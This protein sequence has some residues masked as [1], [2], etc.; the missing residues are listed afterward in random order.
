MMT[1]TDT[2][3]SRVTL[4]QARPGLLAD[5]AR[6][7]RWLMAATIGLIAVHA[8]HVFLGERVWELDRIFSLD[9]ESNLPT[10]FSSLMWAGAAI[11]AYSC[12][13]LSRLSQDRRLWTVLA[14]VLMA[15]S[16]DE[17]ATLHELVGKLT[18]TAWPLV[19][20]PIAVPAMIWMGW[21]LRH[22]LARSSGAAKRIA[23]GVAALCAAVACELVMVWL[24]ERPNA[25]ALLVV[26]V[27]VEESL[28][29]FGVALV[30]TGLMWHLRALRAGA[31]RRLV[32]AARA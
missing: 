8:A 2:R 6:L 23:A 27:V 3:V 22:L 4:D 21:R 14:V 7:S 29:L 5:P 25:D 12:G 24:Q 1:T 31:M 26:E 19:L 17:V 9:R 28:E 15:F 11:T 32:A 20:A 10:W 18:A 30:L 16:C 13:C